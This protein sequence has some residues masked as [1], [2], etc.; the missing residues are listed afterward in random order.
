MG[1]P[2]SDIKYPVIDFL[3]SIAGEIAIQ[4]ICFF[5][6]GPL[7]SKHS[8]ILYELTQLRIAKAKSGGVTYQVD[9]RSTEGLRGAVN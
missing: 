3:E 5:Y 9:N 7:H 8:R 4:P 6:L 1:P 2:L